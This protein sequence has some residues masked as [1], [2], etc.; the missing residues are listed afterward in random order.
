MPKPWNFSTALSVG[1]IKDA[2]ADFNAFA[3]SDALIP[4]SRIAVRYKARSC[5]L[6]PSP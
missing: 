6:P 5:T 4:P 3:P 2:R 1:L